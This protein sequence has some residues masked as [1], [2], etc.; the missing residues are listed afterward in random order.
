MKSHQIA[1]ITVVMGSFILSGCSIPYIYNDAPKA[2]VK[3]SVFVYKGINFGKN[4][5]ADFKRGVIDG[6]TTASGKYSK[7]HSSFNA[8]LSYRTGWEDGRLKCKS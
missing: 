8:N 2:T 1:I 7:D 3:E 6:C 5:D 4:R